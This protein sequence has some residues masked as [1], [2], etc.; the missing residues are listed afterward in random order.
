MLVF[1]F[2]LGC[3]VCLCPCSGHDML[4]LYPSSCG[5]FVRVRAAASVA[6][7]A[8]EHP[9]LVSYSSYLLIGVAL[10]KFMS[11]H[12]TQSFEGSGIL[13]FLTKLLSA[14]QAYL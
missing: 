4:C 6:S 13:G 12:Y 3:G 10:V 14:A 9:I 11:S 1:V 8:S 5:T 7:P 2:L